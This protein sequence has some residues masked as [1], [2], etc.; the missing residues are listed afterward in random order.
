MFGRNVTPIVIPLA[1]AMCYN[2]AS[3]TARKQWNLIFKNK[4]DSMN[5][6]TFLG[7]AVALSLIFAVGQ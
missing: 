6:K 2:M 4:E 3:I 5:T 1:E 7:G